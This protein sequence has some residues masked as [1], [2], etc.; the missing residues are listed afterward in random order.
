[1]TTFIVIGVAAVVI[2]F[3][4]SF[5]RSF[6][7]TRQ[8]T[9]WSSDQAS[10]S[11]ARRDAARDRMTS[12]AERYFPFVADRVRDRAAGVSA[13][14]ALRDALLDVPGTTIGTG[15]SDL[16]VVI[17]Y[18][19][20]T[21]HVA[22]FGRSGTGKTSLMLHFLDDDLQR[23][24]GVV[25][26]TAEEE[27]CRD[28]VL[29]RIPEARIGDV[30]LL[31]PGHNCPIRWNP[32]EVEPGD[33]PARWAAEVY[34][35][36]RAA[37][38][39][40]TIGPRSDALARHLFAALV[41]Y[42]GA[43]FLDVRPFLEDAEFRARVLATCADEQARAFWTT[44]YPKYPENAILPLTQRT[45]RFS[46]AAVRDMLCP[47]RSSVS[48]RTLLETSKIVLVDLSGL[49]PD[50]T[51]LLGQLFLARLQLEIMRRE[52]VAEEQRPFT[53]LYVDECHLWTG[54]SA[55]WAQLTSRARRYQCGL[56]I[57][58]QFP[59]Q[60][61]DVKREVLGNTSCIVSFAV[62]AE[63][64]AVLRRELIVP[65][66][67][68]GG[69]SEIAAQTLVTLR[70]GQAVVRTTTGSLAMP[71]NV[72]PPLVRHEIARG[73]RVRARSW[74]TYGTVL[75]VTRLSPTETCAAAATRATAG[76]SPPHEASTTP[77]KSGVPPCDQPLP[78]RGSDHHKVLQ[79]F[80][81]TLGTERGFRTNVEV[82]ILGGAG[83]ADVTLVRDGDDTRLAVEVAVTSTLRQIG[84]AV[85]KD[86]AAGFAHVIVLSGDEELLL[87]AQAYVVETLVGKDRARVHFLNPDG[88]RAFLDA[89]PP[90]ESSASRVAGFR[91][92]VVDE[93][94]APAVLRVRRHTLAR[95]VGAAVLRTRVRS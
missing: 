84:S 83:R 61:G 68:N 50:T 74:Q 55:V 30:V 5:V 94:V 35:A 7:Q 90:P 79:Q 64:A 17:P 71:V 28:D 87:R 44:S 15:P 75:P 9:Q 85:T 26:L 63:N 80:V 93:E 8:R 58:S 88:L 22:I 37:V 23:G 21:R 20:R 77:T 73:K 91:L 72:H 45:D 31:A 27:S 32:L 54:T 62:S 66:G 60:L 53:A 57:A 11:A 33:D 46:A 76:P 78:G 67:S 65:S 19:L 43:T 24:A 59:A 86:L 40:S 47:E 81:A 82:E 34:I 48:L 2:T 70:V 49:D 13:G 39:E 10:W 95:L 25:V 4:A 56:V 12:R 1:M 41:P 38:G 18:H 36:L 3:V 89:M 6:R 16:P 51:A 42:P 52:R 29:P 92:E 14:G 69:T